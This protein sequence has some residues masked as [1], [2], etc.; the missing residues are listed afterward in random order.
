MLP[1]VLLVLPKCFNA[2]FIYEMVQISELSDNTMGT[3]VHKRSLLI[4]F[5]LWYCFCR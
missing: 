2:F 4:A 1:R 3:D 5:S